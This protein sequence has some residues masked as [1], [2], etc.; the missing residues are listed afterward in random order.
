MVFNL[1]VMDG[2]ESGHR[3]VTYPA[4]AAGA[5]MRDGSSAK[6]LGKRSAYL[7]VLQAVLLLVLAAVS[8]ILLDIPVWMFT[9]PHTEVRSALMAIVVAPLS[10]GLVIYWGY[11]RSA[12]PLR[13]V[14]P[15]ASI[16]LL[17]A[18]AMI[19]M[20]LGASVLVLESNYV[21][22]L[23][24]PKPARLVN[25]EQGL[26]H[27]DIWNALIAPVVVGPLTE[28]F[29]FRGLILQG[30]LQNYGRRK[31]LLVSALLFALFHLNPWQFSGA[32]VMGVVFGWWLIES[33]SLLPC[34][35]GHALANLLPWMAGRYSTGLGGLK[36]ATVFNPVWFGGFAVFGA[37]SLLTGAWLLRRRAV[38]EG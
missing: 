14:F 37:L 2:R 26:R 5:N 28:E 11:R 25:I 17:Q 7:R 38:R 31:A 32:L 3:S 8:R 34:L 36:A 21:V 35:L 9:R 15:L 13:A 24:W 29:L 30:F 12:S 22:S 19:L 1:T 27:G 20:L 18:A 4:A 10:M 6:G 16:R 33:G 23:V